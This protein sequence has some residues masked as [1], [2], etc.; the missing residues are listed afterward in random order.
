MA[1]VDNIMLLLRRRTWTQAHVRTLVRVCPCPPNS[2][3]KRI[4][5]SVL[6][7]SVAIGLTGEKSLITII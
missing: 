3:M 4:Q 7:I 1:D 6:L 2:G 5:N